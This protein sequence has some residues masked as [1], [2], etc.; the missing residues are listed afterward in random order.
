[1]IWFSVWLESELRQA[2][3]RSVVDPSLAS[4]E[5]RSPSKPADVILS[6]RSSVKPDTEDGNML[7]LLS[8]AIDQTGY[9]PVPSKTT[10]TSDPRTNKAGSEEGNRSL[11]GVPTVPGSTTPLDPKNIFE[12]AP[13]ES[14]EATMTFGRPRTL[15]NILNEAPMPDLPSELKA[16][17][18]QN[19]DPDIEKDSPSQAEAEPVLWDLLWPG[20]HKDLPNP[21]LMEHM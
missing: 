17:P 12:I 16:Y 1:V 15:A 13:A 6:D 14:W 10:S 7:V 19:I 21:E 18:L 3:N 11:V 9:E 20:W 8:Q 4:V 5:V 2:K